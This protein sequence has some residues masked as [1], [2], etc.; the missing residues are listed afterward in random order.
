M[1][2]DLLIVLAAVLGF[3]TVAGLGFV[4]AG[5]DGGQ[6]KTAKRVQAVAGS[7]AEKIAAKKPQPGDT[8]SVRRKQILD[9]LRASE[10]QQRKEKL[11]IEARLQQAGLNISP[12]QFWIGSVAFGLFAG[13]LCLL[14]RLSPAI[15]LGVGF[16]VGFG[17]PRWMLGF[18]CSRRHKKFT[19]EFPN[20]IDIV[21]RGIKSGLPV[22]DCLRVIARETPQPLAAEFTKVVESVGMGLS[23]TEALEKMY[24]RMPTAE[25]RFLS[26]V[27]AIQSKT[28]GNLAEALNNLS[29]VL[30]AR[31]LMREK[32]KAM[33]GEAVASAFI[34][35]SLPPGIMA[36]VSISS[37]GYMSPMFSDPRGHMMLLGGAVW[38][39]SGV[40]VMRKMINFKI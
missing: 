13:L 6:A 35:G 24:T 21:V 14:F 2:Q 40:F 26:I 25:V 27:M 28:G 12:R 34:I 39:A 11:A 3:I 16:A 36:L 30:R 31:K 17:L 37:P 32:V 20:A 22:N 23:I 5:G 29:T 8:A 9:G 38:M 1:S 19:E 7:R 10:R 18:L 4:L 33:S 15:A